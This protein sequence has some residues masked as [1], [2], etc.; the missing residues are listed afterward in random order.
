[1]S[2]A[3]VI[4]GANF[5]ANKVET[6]TI[7]ESVPCTDI[8]LSESAIALDT[9]NETV[10]LVATLTPSNT[11][12]NLSWA[13]S[14]ENVATVADG[15]VT[16]VGVGSATVT[17]TC[18]NQNAMVSVSCTDLVTLN[19]S[20][21][22]LPGYRYSGSLDL[23]ATPPHDGVGLTADQSS[24][25]FYSDENTLNGYRAFICNSSTQELVAGKYPIPI[26]SGANQMTI[27]VPATVISGGYRIRAVLLN[28][29]EQQTYV[30][31]AIDGNAA[32]GVGA[33]NQ[34][35]GTDPLVIN[36]SN[37]PG[38]NAF[39]VSVKDNGSTTPDNI[40]DV[41]VKFERV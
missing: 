10:T 22:I 39:V 32:K 6:V 2:K 19:D 13:S 41:A 24:E 30:S 7:G 3:L 28:A 34:N 15:V 25:T 5:S 11:T 9:L 1:M 26:P 36:L 20:Y 38:A 4:K 33:I 40:G 17:A 12:D 35:S 14:N 8:S 16:C 23:S 29:N 21:S 27:T 18:G 31:G 37:Y